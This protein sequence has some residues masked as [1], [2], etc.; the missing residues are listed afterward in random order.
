[1]MP[2]SLCIK[3][4]MPETGQRLSDDELIYKALLNQILSVK[5]KT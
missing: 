2:C 3:Q 5:E 1:M 4:L